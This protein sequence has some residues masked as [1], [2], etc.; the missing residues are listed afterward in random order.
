MREVSLETITER[1]RSL[2]PGRETIAVVFG[3]ITAT[4]EQI[5]HLVYELYGLSIEEIASIE[6]PA[7]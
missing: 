2:K 5:D 7:S 3:A 4:D 6:S 1:N